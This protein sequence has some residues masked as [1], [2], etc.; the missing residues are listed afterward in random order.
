MSVNYHA[1][2]NFHSANEA[3]MDELLCTLKAQ[4]RS[5]PVQARRREQAVKLRAAE[6]RE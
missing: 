1:I 6:A 4:A 2:N 5:E 3:L